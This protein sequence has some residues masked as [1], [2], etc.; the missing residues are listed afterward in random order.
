[1]QCGWSQRLWEWESCIGGTSQEAVS[2]RAAAKTSRWAKS[3]CSL[4]RC[5]VWC[6]E[7]PGCPVG[8][9]RDKVR[10]QKPENSQRQENI[11]REGFQPRDGHSWRWCA[12]RSE[13]NNCF[14]KNSL[15]GA[16][17]R[18][19]Q[20]RSQTRHPIKFAGSPPHVNVKLSVWHFLSFVVPWSFGL[21]DRNGPRAGT[22][23]SSRS[24]DLHRRS[25]G[26]RG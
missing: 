10:K 18:F 6:A 24:S 12:V 11:N 19:V 25:E 16:V 7:A 8:S 4:R 5:E 13:R 21:W 3:S 17:K 15:Y 26:Q 14:H 9:G 2:T 20:C 1:M 23:T 22:S